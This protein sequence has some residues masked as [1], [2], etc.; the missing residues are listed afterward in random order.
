MQ[1][2][3][4]EKDQLIGELRQRI[5][6]LEA[7]EADRKASATE[8]KATRQRLQYLLAVSP[9]IIY[10]TKASGDHACTFVTENLYAITGC[11]P[12]EMTNNPKGWFDHLHPDDVRRVFDELPHLIE[13]GEGTVEYRFRH[14]DGHYIWIRDTFKVRHGDDGRPLELVGAWTEV[15]KRKQAEQIAVEAKRYL[16]RLIESSPDA[17][18]STDTENNV[19]LFN[20]GAES[21]LGY[22][23]E[24]VI[25]Q[26]VSVLYGGEVRANNVQREA[27][28]RGGTVSGF[29]SALQT[30]DGD[31]IP[32][33]ISASALFD[34][35][36]QQ[37]GMV[38]FATDL[39]KRKR[40]DEALQKA[41]EELEKTIEGRTAELK[42]ARE[43]LQYLMTVAPGIIYTN[44]ASGDY[45]CTFVSE[46]VDEIMGF[47]PWE[48]LD[49][50]DF[51][52][53]RIHP[54]DRKRVFDEMFPLLEQGG[55][56][57]EY[58]FRHQSGNYIWIQD[59]FKVVYDDQGRPS[60]IVGSWADISDRKQAEQA[61]RERMAVM[62][63]LQAL[64]GASPAI[65][66]TRKAAGDFACSFISENLNSIM[67]YAPWEM[68]E[69]QKFWLKH[70]HPEDSAKALTE[71]NRLID[72][73]G[74]ALEY[75]FRHRRGH[76]VWIQDTFTVTY[77]DK[78][79]P[80][81][82]IGSW[83]DISERKCIEAELQ[84]L[85]EQVEVRN[86]F[87]RGIFGRYL[88]DEVVDTVLESPTGLQVGG[89][90]RKVT[91]LMTDLRGFTSLS[92]RM[93]P[94]QVVAMLNRYLGTMVEVI[95]Q[96]QGTI[97]EFIG[98]SI[99]V[100][101]GAPV[102]QENDA[103][104][105]VACAI[106]M[107]QA[108]ASFNEQDRQEGLPEIEMGIGIHT[109]EVVVGNVG[110]PERMKY[111]VVGRHVNLT[112]RI[113]SYTVGG[114]ILIS[115]TTRKEV[116]PI[117]RIGKHLEIK[118]K[119]IT[120]PI[121]LSEIVG[122]D[123]PHEL[124]V[125]QT[126]EE[127]VPLPEALPFTYAIVEGAHLSDD[128][129]RGRMTQLSAKA[130]QAHFE[131][132]VPKLSDI[133]IH[134]IGVEGQKIPGTLYAKVVETVAASN[135]DFV[136]R[137]TSISPEIETFLDVLLASA[138]SKAKG[139]KQETPDEKRSRPQ[140]RI[141]RVV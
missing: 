102:W 33:L 5:S 51:W 110:S 40:E 140:G 97:D 34:D 95:K 124:F 83:A 20:R 71:I 105:A 75:R 32:V 42:L 23:P 120:E 64:V 122:I 28:K 88:T 49:D 67:G 21:L 89:E 73:D 4:K 41:R 72:Q 109:G 3:A 128:V 9:A 50:P 96:Y 74:G 119:G 107:Q 63:D 79:K 77:D 16:A 114:Q 127:L 93:E 18:I 106:A 29:E 117:L 48:M 54:D 14:R 78:G 82:I 99:F 123:S 19:V 35:E 24:E 100:L 47:A 12:Q 131:N 81:E 121:R 43:R 62:K 115:E 56:I 2:K 53:S 104:R 116:S 66:Y 113:H 80:K 126:A 8:L 10:T 1:D 7:F 17:I 87:I 68:R 86:K 130:A 101:F 112:S 111:G 37:A 103:E 57:L 27:R 15:T 135:T 133:E 30:K 90:K 70:L 38:A 92:E 22:R 6:E 118:A 91:M 44:R 61:L 94:E 36:H 132:P 136:I 129:Y 108:M 52:S 13:R 134:F 141:L 31:D 26:P 69:D 76:Y 39:R 138:G 98:D 58:R 11:M 46:N 25:G 45:A 137:F 85:A 139:G 60:E 55:G 65:I 84:E 125:P 59:S